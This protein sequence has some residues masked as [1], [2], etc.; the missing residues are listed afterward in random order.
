VAKGVAD[1]SEQEHP[2]H[3]V[4]NDDHV[5]GVRAMRLPTPARWPHQHE[6]PEGEAE[7]ASDSQRYPK[8]SNTDER[9]HERA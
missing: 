6:R 2:E 7:E 5:L 4:D 3:T 1:G 8:P 9:I